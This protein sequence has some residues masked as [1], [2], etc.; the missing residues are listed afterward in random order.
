MLSDVP[1]RAQGGFLDAPNC[2]IIYSLSATSSQ[3]WKTNTC[4]IHCT[5]NKHNNIDCT[6]LLLKVGFK[7]IFIRISAAERLV[8]L[9]FCAI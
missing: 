4:S 5:M 6:L 7:V 1:C 9:T 8:G 2:D 3:F